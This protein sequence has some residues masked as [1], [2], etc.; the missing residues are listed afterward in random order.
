MLKAHAITVGVISLV[1]LLIVGGIEFPQFFSYVA[2]FGIT[3]VMSYALYMSILHVVKEAMGINAQEQNARF[4]KERV[5][6]IARRK[7]RSKHI[8]P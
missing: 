7:E 5:E 6:R 8:L 1:V 3:I 2:V 4:E